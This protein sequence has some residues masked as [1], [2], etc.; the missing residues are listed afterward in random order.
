MH[1][2]ELSTV[3]DKNTALYERYRPQYP[4]ELYKEI[5]RFA[6][7]HQSSQV[8][9]IGIGAGNA[10]LPML[11]TGCRL[12]AV[13]P[14]QKFASFCQEKFSNYPSFCVLNDKF[15]EATLTK[16]SFDLIF[17]A[18]AFHWIEE[19][20]GFSKVYSLLRNNGLFALF[21]NHPFA[22]ADEPVLS[23]EI[24][25]IYSHYYYRFWQKAPKVQI[26]FTENQARIKSLRGEKY[27]F[28]IG[29]Y[30]LFQRSRILNSD[31]YIALLSTYSD[32][33]SIEESIRTKFFLAIKNAIRRHGDRLTVR[34]TI[35]LELWIKRSF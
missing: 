16:N 19:K 22:C 32:H 20:T 35:D 1:S 12:T 28:E 30:G 6:P 8:L 11:K 13:E 31:D 21:A 3:F 34:D 4:H 33:I 2:S 10:T 27:G 9:E 25:E 29:K 24:Q 15:E 17:S 5:F 18:S 26:E 14:S 7:I 23:E